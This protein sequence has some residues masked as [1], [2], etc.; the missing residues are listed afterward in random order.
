M[1]GLSHENSKGEYSL[2]GAKY[3][4]RNEIL[5]CQQCFFA[6]SFFVIAILIHIDCSVASYLSRKEAE[7]RPEIVPSPSLRILSSY[8]IVLQKLLVCKPL[9][10]IDIVRYYC[11][12]FL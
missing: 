9:Q 5:C 12:H 10:L 6:Q 1:K 4:I 8:Q 2:S 11:F 3:I 7:Q